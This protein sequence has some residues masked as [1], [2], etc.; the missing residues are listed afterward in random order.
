MFWKIKNSVCGHK[1]V[2]YIYG[3]LKTEPR[4]SKCKSSDIKRQMITF[5]REG[6]FSLDG[7][8]PALRELSSKFNVSVATVRKAVVQLE[9]SGD[10][11]VR[12]GSGVYVVDNGGLVTETTILR[13]VRENKTICVIDS[14]ERDDFEGHYLDNFVLSEVLQGVQDAC[15]KAQWGL[16][17]LSFIINEGEQAVLH[18][19]G[20]CKDSIALMVVSQHFLGLLDSVQQMGVPAVVLGPLGS[21]T[22]KYNEV[23]I[24]LFEAGASVGEHLVSLGHQKVLYIGQNP[25]VAKGSYLRHAGFCYAH[26]RAFPEGK[27]QE[28]FVSD[29]TNSSVFRQMFVG[30]AEKVLEAVNSVSAIFIASDQIALIVVPYLLQHGVRIPQ[31]VSLITLDNSRFTKLFTPTWTSV[32]LNRPGAAMKAFEFLSAGNNDSSVSGFS[33]YF[34]PSK[35][36]IRGSAVPYTQ[37]ENEK[38]TK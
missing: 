20:E 38:S 21:K 36:V 17:V 34:V 27:I 6:K 32:D 7:K 16:K 19:I 2:C 26:K 23:C 4:E 18:K 12:H 15:R 11:V 5:L 28:I 13:P 29:A 35:L 37:N 25:A 9:Q 8:L 14:F 3:M 1:E 24:D 10:V 33:K 22:G 31:T 30:A